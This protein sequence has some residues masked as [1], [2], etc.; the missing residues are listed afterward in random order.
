VPRHDFTI[1][2]RVGSAS[3]PSRRPALLRK[4]QATHS[5]IEHNAIARAPLAFAGL[6][7]DCQALTQHLQTAERLRTSLVQ[8]GEFAG[9][10]QS[11]AASIAAGLKGQV[12]R[13]QIAA[14]AEYLAQYK[15]LQNA[16]GEFETLAGHPL[17]ERNNDEF[18]SRLDQQM[19][20]LEQSR[21]LF[22]DWSS[23]CAVRARAIAKGLAPLVPDLE[24]GAVLPDD[25]VRAFR[26]GYARWWLPLAIDASANCAIFGASSTNTPLW[27]SEKLMISC[28]PMRQIR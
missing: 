25:A 7:T 6:D 17:A 9:D 4:L 11:V 21:N 14:A 3:Q 2:G 15:A 26:L 10:V 13:P 28:E 23:W 8:L 1:R 18:L 19:D 27:T 24:N 16:I 20:E 12:N 5:A 22:R